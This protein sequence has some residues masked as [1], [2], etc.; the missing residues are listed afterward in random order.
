MAVYIIEYE[1]NT[2][3]KDYKDLFNIIFSYRNW[4]KICKSSWAIMTTESA[5]QVRENLDKHLDSGDKL[6][7]AELTGHWASY[8]LPEKVTDWLSG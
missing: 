7:V 5:A 8:G 3:G 1:L 2:P 6:F 4:A